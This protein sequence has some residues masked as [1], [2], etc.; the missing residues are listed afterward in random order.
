[1]QCEYKR[2]EGRPYLPEASAPCYTRK[3]L[4]T[5]VLPLR[6]AAQ[7]NTLILILAV[8]VQ[9]VSCSIHRQYPLEVMLVW[10]SLA[11]LSQHCSPNSPEKQEHEWSKALDTQEG[12]DQSNTGDYS[13]PRTLSAHCPL[14]HPGSLQPTA[15]GREFGHSLHTAL[16]TCITGA[17]QRPANILNGAY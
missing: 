3:K 4:I 5:P 13:F 10:Q 6:T 9:P 14:L 1:M 8:R 11:S 16:C 2:S 17:S 15:A 7:R 12:E